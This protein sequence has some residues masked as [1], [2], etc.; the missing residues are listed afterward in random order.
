MT[1]SG[2]RE[3]LMK[4]L[5]T[6]YRRGYDVT[7]PSITSISWK[8]NMVITSGFP[9]WLF[10]VYF[11]FSRS[12]ALFILLLCFRVCAVKVYAPPP[13]LSM[14]L[15]QSWLDNPSDSLLPVKNKGND[16]VS[17]STIIHEYVSIHFVAVSYTTFCFF[18]HPI[19][20][21]FYSDVIKAAFSLFFLLF[22]LSC[23]MYLPLFMFHFN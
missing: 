19:M 12:L 18:F 21:S 4:M 14:L 2:R 20:L 23:S 10:F 6:I 8:K 13:V 22:F 17:C 5:R 3:A 1:W 15:S 9:R 7:T 16:A 11:I